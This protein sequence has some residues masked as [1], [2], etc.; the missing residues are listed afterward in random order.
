MKMRLRL[1]K[2]IITIED[3]K[4]NDK[5]KYQ[6]VFTIFTIKKNI[7]ITIYAIEAYFKLNRHS[8]NI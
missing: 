1:F 5:L 6:I 2:Y 3:F 4:N 7:Y 8:R